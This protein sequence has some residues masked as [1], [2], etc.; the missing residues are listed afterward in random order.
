MYIC[1]KC[2]IKTKQLN[3]SYE[4]K[5]WLCITCDKQEKKPFRKEM[6]TIKDTLYAK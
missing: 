5:Q 6:R 2:K 1:N 3:W 4:S